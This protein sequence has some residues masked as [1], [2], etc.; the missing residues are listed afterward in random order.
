MEDLIHDNQ[1]AS[2]YLQRGKPFRARQGL[3]FCQPADRCQLLA[4]IEQ[5]WTE[6][7]KKKYDPARIQKLY[8]QLKDYIEIVEVAQPNGSFI[9]GG[10]FLVVSKSAGTYKAEPGTKSNFG[11]KV[12]YKNLK[13]LQGH[14]NIIFGAAGQTYQIKSTAIDSLGTSFKKSK[15]GDSCSGPVSATCYGTADFRAKANLTDTGGSGSSDTI[16]TT[17]WNDNTRLFS[18]SG[19]GSKT[20]RETL[21]GGNLVVHETR[22]CKENRVAAVRERMAAT[23][24]IF[25][26][27]VPAACGRN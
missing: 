21:G 24:F 6:L 3:E 9:T 7:A 22:C 14:A 23:L 10:G 17:L 25:Q 18:F 19:S 4:M 13:S 26:G 1:T 16:A 5:L 27:P 2:R 20:V 15:G 12:N 8:N 11:F